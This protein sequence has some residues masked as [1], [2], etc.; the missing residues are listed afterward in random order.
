MPDTGM[1]GGTDRGGSGRDDH[2]AWYDPEDILDAIGVKPG[3]VCAD[4]GCGVGTFTMPL[5]RRAGKDGRVYA[6]DASVAA[7]DMLKVKKPGVTITTLRAELSE[8]R[9]PTGSCDLVLLPFSL[10]YASGAGAILSEAARLL[11]DGGRV[12]VVEWRPV[13]P[14]PGPPMS[15]RTRSDRMQRLLES[16]GFVNVKRVREG[17]VYYTLVAEKGKPSTRPQSQTAQ[18]SRTGQRR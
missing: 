9:L 18:P 12:A 15:S 10:S 8:T 6:V 7:L 16:H 3:S 13:P 11:K 4:L 5:A 14:P 2:R 17:A 1:P